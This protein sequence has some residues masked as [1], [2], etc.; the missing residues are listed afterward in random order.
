MNALSTEE[1]ILFAFVIIEVI[2][3]LWFCWN[4]PDVGTPY[5]IESVDDDE[6]DLHE[7]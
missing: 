1:K 7:P 3:V 2:A 5:N 4:S 6:T